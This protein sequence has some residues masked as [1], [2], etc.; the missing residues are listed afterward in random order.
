MARPM[1]FSVARVAPRGVQMKKIGGIA[2]GM[3]GGVDWSQWWTFEDYR[4]YTN[5]QVFGIGLA[6]Y[7][8]KPPTLQAVVAGM[9]AVFSF[10]MAN[11]SWPPPQGIPAGQI[12]YSGDK[13]AEAA[14]EAAA[15][16]AGVMFEPDIITVAM[17]V[18]AP[19]WQAKYTMSFGAG[20]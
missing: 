14:A 7:A 13:K 2:A 5:L 3:L 4:I 19:K 10:A 11:A 16:V 9:D 6:A 17:Q 18:L 1:K 15:E 8:G 20:G 12:G